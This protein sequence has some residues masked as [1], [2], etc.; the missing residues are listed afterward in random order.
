MRESNPD[1]L[2]QFYSIFTDVVSATFGLGFR[3][4]L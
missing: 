1:F 4:L 2:F 3:Q